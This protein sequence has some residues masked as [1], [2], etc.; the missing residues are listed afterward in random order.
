VSQREAPGVSSKAPSV[1]ATSLAAENE[2]LRRELDAVRSRLGPAPSAHGP[3]EV[4]AAWD[5]HFA[6]LLPDAAYVVLD[7]DTIAAIN[8][9]GV[10]QFGAQSAEEIVGR[11]NY[12]LIHPEHHADT[13]DHIARVKNRRERA[14]FLRRRRLRLDGS[15]YPAEVSAMRCRY[16]DCEAQLVIVRDL[17]DRVRTDDELTRSRAILA[18]AAGS[19]SDGLAIFDATGRF[20][21]A[22]DKFLQHDPVRDEVLNPGVSFE[23]FIRHTLKRNPNVK[24]ED[25]ENQVE[26]RLKWYATAGGTNEFRDSMGRWFLTSHRKTPNGLTV[27]LNTDITERKRA[28]QESERTADRL[29]VLFDSSPDAIYVHKAGIIQL[30]NPAAVKL[31]GATSADELIGRSV[32]DTVHPETRN[33]SAAAI[34]VDPRQMTGPGPQEQRRIKLDGTEFWADIR[35]APLPWDGDV[36]TVVFLRDATG[37]KR[38]REAYD[39]QQAFLKEAIESISEGLWIFDGAHKLVASN[40]RLAEMLRYPADLLESGTPFERLMRFAVERG[41]FGAGDREQLLAERLKTTEAKEPFMFERAAPGGSTL[42]VRFAPMSNGG[43]VCTMADI[44]ARK[45]FETAL[46]ELNGRLL[47]Q[48]QELR[49]SN[50]ELEQFAYVA[51]HDLQ[52]PLRSIGSYCQLLQRRYKGKL[53]KDADEFID[54]AVDGAKRMQ[55]LMNDL[56]KYSRVGT[57]GKPFEATDCNAVFNDAVSNLRQAIEEAGATVV[58]DPLPIVSGD[59]VQLGQLFQNLIA[60]AIKFRGEAAPKVHVSASDEG[61]ET[62]FSVKDNGIGVDARH[63]DR[64]FQI[65]QRLHERGKYPGTG[66]GLAVCKKIVARHGGRIWVE[67]APGAGAEFRFSLA[68]KHDSQEETGK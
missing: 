67:S 7:D 53:D 63:A 68:P 17:S 12:D 33:K 23:Q 22:N 42:E 24:P 13:R 14:A 41:D 27:I 43:F 51:S 34:Q 45:E 5:G 16:R 46:A 64:I 25:V 11:N 39:L 28:Q 40:R 20:V 31:F 52:E 9:A 44:T 59:A 54:F 8:S 37:R 57:R 62:I 3:R 55:V 10:R 1:A 21:F 50:E 32:L 58:C 35:I 19:I 56:L 36:G 26:R 66:I 30:A 49:R 29:R 4:G 61:G 2:A 6:E 15:E 60:N 48:T 65:F 38:M 47:A 18:D